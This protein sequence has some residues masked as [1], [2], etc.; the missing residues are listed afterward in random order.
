MLHSK[1]P[2]EKPT[3][4]LPPLD[5][6][7]FV[8]FYELL[9]LAL[10]STGSELRK[11]IG[12]LYL[13]AQKN[14]D[15]RDR[16]KKLFFQQMYEVHLPRARY[17]LLDDKRRLEYDAHTRTFR[18]DR[19]QQKAVS[20]A[21]KDA[22]VTKSA[23]TA[24]ALATLQ[25]AEIDDEM[26]PEDVATR[27]ETLWRHWQ[28]GL[29][30]SVAAP[31]TLSLIFT[32][33]QKVR[34]EKRNVYMRQTACVVREEERVRREESLRRQQQRWEMEQNQAEDERRQAQAEQQRE[35]EQQRRRLDLAKAARLR[36]S[37]GSGS[38]AFVL[39]A[40]LL[41]AL[42]GASSRGI[43][44]ASSEIQLGHRPYH[45]TAASVP[46]K[47]EIE[48]YDLGVE[49]TA[50]HKKTHTINGGGD[51]R[52][53]SGVSMTSTDSG[54]AVTATA[55]GEWLDFTINPTQSGLYDIAVSA[56]SPAGGG[57]FSVG[58]DK[59]DKTGTLVVPATGDF[60]KYQ[61]VEKKNVALSAGQQVMRLTFA[62]AS[63]DGSVGNFDSIELRPG[64][65]VSNGW[66]STLGAFVKPLLFAVLALLCFALGRGMGNLAEKRALKSA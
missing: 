11:A 28:H 35:A 45:G 20:E 38:G 43:A 4:Q 46:G 22:A 16:Q 60:S 62:S 59:Q 63:S 27:R 6:D 13:E 66:A 49:G 1:A 33:E 58:F 25:H 37:W 17:V 8:D 12:A 50:Y 23:P 2:F 55:R 24:F 26:A 52:S 7:T 15:H 65:A 41:F 19:A 34:E 61:V 42:T 39:G 31:Q 10:S 47:I 14:L 51:Y 5:M 48:D 36:W 21:N 18:A 29:E 3:A 9:G 56:S 54:H 53:G 64:A 30:T 32:P 57:T 44:T 40:L